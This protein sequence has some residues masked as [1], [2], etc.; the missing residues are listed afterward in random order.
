MP[1]IKTERREAILD[2]VASELGDPEFVIKMSGIEAVGDLN[3]AITK[4]VDYWLGEG[5][6][7]TDINEVVGV[8]ECAKL[9]VYRRVGV[10]IEEVAC[11]TRGDVYASQS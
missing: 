10:A 5:P 9:E 3:Y 7:Y 11:A 8:L 6:T 1:Y 4:L 2:L